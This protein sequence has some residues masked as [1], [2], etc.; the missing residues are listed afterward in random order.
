MATAFFNMKRAGLASMWFPAAMVLLLLLSVPGVVLLALNL[1][2]WENAVNEWMQTRWSL[3]YHIPIPRWASLLLVLAPFLIILLY[4]LKLKRKPLQVP[5]TF[6][7]RKSIED[8]HV[9]SLFQWLR[10]NV[11]LLIQLLIVLI[12]I[13]AVLGF[14]VHAHTG[15]GHYYIIMVD[16]SASMAVA[17]VL[18]TRLEAAKRAAVNEID[19]HLEGDV[20]MVIEFNS[21]AKILQPYT[22]DRNLLRVAVQGIQ[23]T[24][25]STHVEEALGLADSLAN[26]RQTADDMAV[27]PANPIP[28]QERTYV[29]AE[30][31]AADVHLFSDGRFP[32]VPE[33]SAGRLNLN[34]HR[35][36][37]AGPEVDNVAIVAFNATRDEQN[38]GKVR[39]FVRV[40]NY[41]QQE[42]EGKV[43]LEVRVQDQ[44]DFKLYDK[45]T[46]PPTIPAR[47]VSAGDPDKNEPP[48]DIPG[49]GIATFELNDMDEAT[50]VTLHAQLVGV[51]DAFPLDD[52][53]WLVLGMVRKA[54]I[55]IVAPGTVVGADGKLI[56]P[57]N[58]ILNDF[59]GQD[60]VEKVATITY[61][62]P[63]DLGSEADYRRP[64]RNGAFDLVI[65]DR[66]APASVD[67][68]PLGNTF[69][70]DSVP[71]PWKRAD[72]PPL[73]DTIIRNPAS[74][75]PIM[76]HLTALDEIA[77]F[78]AF[79]FPLDDPRVSPRTP[80]LL[81]TGKDTAVLLALS[82]QSFTDLVMTFPLINDKGKG[83]TTWNL[84]LSFPVFL[85]NVMYALGNVSDTAAE[86]TI[87]PGELKTLRP[88]VVV[89]KIEVL[90]PADAKPD[91]VKKSPQGDFSYKGTERV[92]VYRAKW[93]DGERSFAVNLLDPEESNLQP[94]DEVT[95]GSTRLKANE[96]KGQ[97][98]D[99]WKW[100]AVGALALLLLEWALYYRRIFT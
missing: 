69:F 44:P 5:S 41:R 84:K 32:D 50:T 86:E 57:G 65:F 83:T 93:K 22:T 52:E 89:D 21:R 68:M 79:R 27:R 1:I 71:P 55:A 37:K 99:T 12:V 77:V 34:Y 54:R 56:T 46:N 48:S 18:P 13:Y 6:L 58:D 97:V 28:G 40:V 3:S 61:L 36:G 59:F 23:Q 15:S 29:A 70:I 73:E 67:E 14:Q 9:N 63:E 94:R 72:M 4:F 30:G 35:I 31:I 25:R 2:G 82:R 100:G 98:H 42:V 20:G 74:K 60:V 49:D 10:D 33:F 38:S 39:V 7:W 62:R 24:Q 91:E 47:K 64:A 90:A 95:F 43:R 26:P 87:Q 80:R 17:D 19:G 8:L 16:N 76:R 53:A 51:K 75:H 11:L 78:E 92:G 66:C 81:E 88:D 85:R 96:T 45:Q